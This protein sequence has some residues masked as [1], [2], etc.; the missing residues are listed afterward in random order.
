MCGL[1]SRNYEKAMRPKRH[2]H[3]V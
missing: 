1:E 3:A 2:I